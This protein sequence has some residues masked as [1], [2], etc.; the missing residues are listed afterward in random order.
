MEN[1]FCLFVSVF[2]F[3]FFCL[4]FCFVL[5]S[6]LFVFCFVCCFLDGFVFLFSLFFCSVFSRLRLFWFIQRLIGGLE[7]DPLSMFFLVFFLEDASFSAKRAIT[8]Q[9]SAVPWPALLFFLS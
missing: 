1:C 7:E 3:V 9:K 8:V 6:L 5:F 2:C 4:S